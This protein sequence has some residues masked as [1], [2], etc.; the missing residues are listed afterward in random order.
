MKKLII[1]L[2]SLSS[3]SL[4]A[5]NYLTAMSDC[6]AQL[7]KAETIQEYTDLALAFERIGIAEKTKWHPYYYQA[8]CLLVKSFMLKDADSRDNI[9]DAAEGIIKKAG[10]L[11][12]DKG[13]LSALQARAFQARLS[14]DPGT[15]AMQYGPK[16]TMLLAEARA[17]N[18][19]NPRVLFLLGQNLLFTPAGFGGGKEK[20][21]PLIEQA[22][23]KFN[24]APV[25]DPLAPS[26]GREEATSLL[27]NAK[28]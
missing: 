2:I 1:I 21:L 7:E 11:G 8:F 19:N 28:K 12:G 27:A 3:F 16:T 22:V 15:R 14:V 9:I 6:L 25:Q 26:W 10:E 20:A 17:Q 23:E 4:S 13:E 18:P 5:Q 24:T